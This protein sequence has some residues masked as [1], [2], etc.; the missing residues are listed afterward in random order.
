[1]D[2]YLQALFAAVNASD[3]GRPDLF[4]VTHVLWRHRGNQA[5]A[6]PPRS[7]QRVL[8]PIV[9]LVG[10]LLGK[11]RGT[12]WPGSPESCPGAPGPE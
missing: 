9:V 7:V 6:A 2:G 12:A 8:F 1:L 5:L 10:R 4:H 11:Y 3:S